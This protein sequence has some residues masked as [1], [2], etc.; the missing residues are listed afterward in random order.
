MSWPRQSVQFKFPDGVDRSV[1]TLDALVLIRIEERLRE[2]RI[3]AA[4]KHLP[5]DSAKLSQ[6]ETEDIPMGAVL[7]WIRSPAGALAACVEAV[8]DRN[9]DLTRDDAVDLCVDI[10]VMGRLIQLINP[11]MPASSTDP[12]SAPVSQ[13]GAIQAPASPP[14]PEAMILTGMAARNSPASEISSSSSP[15][16]TAGASTPGT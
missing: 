5:S 15:G 10:G 4:K 3:A 2:A 8:R 9:Q 12:T 16:S 13:I 7:S 14:A 1:S 6:L 11:R